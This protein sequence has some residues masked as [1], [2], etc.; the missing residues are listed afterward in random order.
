MAQLVDVLG[1]EDHLGALTLVVAD[2]GRAAQVEAPHQDAPLLLGQVAA[3]DAGVR[4]RRGRQP[5]DDGGPPAADTREGQ[6]EEARPVREEDGAEVRRLEVVEGGGGGG[7]HGDGAPRMRSL[8]VTAAEHCARGGYGV[9]R[10]A[11]LALLSR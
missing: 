2:H 10:L 8:P 6:V 5:A 3:A 7:V 4:G 11:I 9:I 1:A